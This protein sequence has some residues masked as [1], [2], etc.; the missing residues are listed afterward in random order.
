MQTNSF[1]SKISGMASKIIEKIML[2]LGVVALVWILAF[3]L[4]AIIDK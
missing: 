2:G 3:L 4:V 1:S